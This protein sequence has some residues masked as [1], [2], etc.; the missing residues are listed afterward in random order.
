M[1]RSIDGDHIIIN[2]TVKKCY[3]SWRITF[4]GHGA[5]ILSSNS[6]EFIVWNI[7]SLG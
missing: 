6:F 1:N 3:Q 4:P 5:S 7:I 2:Q